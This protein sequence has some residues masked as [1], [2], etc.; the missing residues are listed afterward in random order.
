MMTRTDYFR[1]RLY[2]EYTSLKVAPY[3]FTKYIYI[4]ITSNIVTEA[5]DSGESCAFRAFF[6]VNR[7]VQYYCTI[8][9]LNTN[10]ISI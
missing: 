2:L 4:G 1:F 7:A 10:F 3:H 6:E 5:G 9:T 8:F